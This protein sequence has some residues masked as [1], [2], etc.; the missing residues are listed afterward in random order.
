M[1]NICLYTTDCNQSYTATPANSYKEGCYGSNTATPTNSYKEG[2]V[3]S[4]NTARPD[5]ATRKDATAAAWPHQKG[6]KTAKKVTTRA[7]VTSWAESSE[8][9]CDSMMIH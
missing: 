5:K 4:S 3:G 6:E 2:C 8:S 9:S 7:A 1:F